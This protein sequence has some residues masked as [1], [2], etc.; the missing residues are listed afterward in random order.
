MADESS[1]TKTESAKKYIPRP[2]DKSGSETIN[3]ET[4]VGIVW[5]YPEGEAPRPDFITTVE[6][7]VKTEIPAQVLYAWKIGDYPLIAVDGNGNKS[8]ENIR[9]YAVQRVGTI[10]DKRPQGQPQL[11][12]TGGHGANVASVR[13]VWAGGGRVCV[14]SY[15][16]NLG[17]NPW[18]VEGDPQQGDRTARL[19]IQVSWTWDPGP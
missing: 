13:Y 3:V 17:E 1:A 15:S 4:H 5:R 8:L 7:V 2:E 14:Y 11:T 19:E 10:N 9:E 6:N 18:E 12:L 16:L